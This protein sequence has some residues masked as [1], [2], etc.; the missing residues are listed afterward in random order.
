[1]ATKKNTTIN[2]KEY[3]RLRRTIDGKVKAFYGSSKSDAEQKYKHYLERLA[4]EKYSSFV[5][6]QTATIH[7]RAKEYIENSLSV[8][9]RYAEGTKTRYIIAYNAHIK[10]T[11]L[12]KMLA[13]DVRASDIQRFYNKL[14]VSVQTLRQINKFMTG[15]WK[16]MVLNEYA[17]NIMVAVEMPIKPDN[18][19]HEGIQIWEDDEI[20]AI[21]TAIDSAEGTS[22]P[23]RA[24]FL[25]L[26][27]LYTGVR[28]GEALSLRYSDFADGQIRIERQMYLGEIKP[29]KYNSKRTIPMHDA[30]V[31]PLKE[32]RAWHEQEMERKGYQ[33]EYVFTT[34][35]GTLYLSDNVRQTLNRFY[36]KIGVPRKK[37]HTYRSTFC[38]QLCRCD[39]PLEV[40]SKLL[41][42][43]S[44]EV[45]ATHYQLIK[46]DTLED[47]IHK[48][49]Y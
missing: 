15:F 1:M 42:H 18:K 43:K 49:T 17:S 44:L 46:N 10:G 16:W 8:S 22:V 26:V 40:A 20:H 23:V 28:I 25:V 19:R 31:E 27:L 30:L 21:L 29:P 32:H 13:S 45:T 14:M 24:R 11:W 35:N 3:Y 39:V 37:L 36:D 47:A 48:L 38:T 6:R 33:S 41:G 34:R 2:G 7:D 5:K 12:D 9:Q 4:N